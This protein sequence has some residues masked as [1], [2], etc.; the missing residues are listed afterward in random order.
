MDKELIDIV[1]KSYLMSKRKLVENDLGII[2]SN[3]IYLDRYRSNVY[4]IDYVVS[5]LNDD[6]RFI[7]DNEVIKGKRGNWYY[8]YMS[9][10]T[11]YRHRKKAYTNFLRS[12]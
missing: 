2:K 1:S 4:H 7:I 10:P 3:E 8:A 11:Y 6:D 9:P 5:C 12:L